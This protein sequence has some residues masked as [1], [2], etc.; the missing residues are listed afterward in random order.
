MLTDDTALRAA[1]QALAEGQTLL[2]AGRAAESLTRLRRAAAL[3]PG[4][5]GVLYLAGVFAHSGGH[6]LDAGAFLAQARTVAPLAPEIAFACGNLRLDHDDPA[7]AE[8]HF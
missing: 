6:L 8:A 1:E 7:A 2:G 4:D 5:A 3:M